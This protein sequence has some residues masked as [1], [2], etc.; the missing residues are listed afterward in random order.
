MP[1]ADVRTI[2]L[3]LNPLIPEKRL[4]CNSFLYGGWGA[5]EIWDVERLRTESELED[6]PFVPGA[7]FKLKISVNKDYFSVRNGSKCHYE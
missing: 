3:M 2:L 6:F 1:Y 5:E 7:R 4:V